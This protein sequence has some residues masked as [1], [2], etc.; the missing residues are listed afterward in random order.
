MLSILRQQS[1]QLEKELLDVRQQLARFKGAQAE[2]EAALAERDAR[3]ATLEE[4]LG[5][6]R[7]DEREEE[8][9]EEEEP[10]PPAQLVTE[11]VLSKLNELQRQLR[12][13]ESRLTTAELEKSLAEL[14][15][16]THTSRLRRDLERELDGVR[17]AAKQAAAKAATE[18]SVARSTERMLRD[19]S[20]AHDVE[21]KELRGALSRRDEQ[22]VRFCALIRAACDVA[23]AR[24]SAT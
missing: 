15:L 5:R 24:A 16:L 11:D 14:Q 17:A 12:A 10:A 3:I 13:A 2:H 7:G 18:L 20:A 4:E 19:T 21:L 9:E 23:R 1:R 22:I 8:E 6:R